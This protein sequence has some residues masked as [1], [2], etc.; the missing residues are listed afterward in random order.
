MPTVSHSAIQGL[1]LEQVQTRRAQGQGNV[2]LPPTSRTYGEI[3]RENVFTFI[4]ITL[5]FLGVALA[6]VGRPTDAIVSSGVITLN[7]LVSVIQEIRAKRTLD[8]I[9]LLTRPQAT[10]IRAGQATQ[11][12]PEA[13]VIGDVLHV[14]AGD[15]IVLDG[16]ILAGAM[17]V[18]ES[19]LTGESDVIPK[20]VG[21]PVYSGSFCVS[22]SAYLIVEKV[23]SASLAQQITAGARAFR[24]VLTPLQNQVYLV[25][26][27][28]FLVVGYIAF[29]LM[30]NA[31]MYEIKL[32]SSLQRLTLVAGLVPNGLFLSISI[33]YA[34]GA[35]R[36]IRHGVLVQQSNA[37]ESLSNVDV[38]CLDKTG[39]LTTNRLQ[40][41]SLQPLAV[42]EA[43]LRRVL[44]ALVASAT[45]RNKTSEALAE[46]YPG[47]TLPVIAEI[48]FSSARKWSAVVFDDPTL[49]GVV[50]LGAP[51][52]V[53]PY[54]RENATEWQ[55]LGS[56]ARALED[57]GLRVVLVAQHAEPGL[58]D[59]GDA[60]RLPTGMIPLG[61]VSLS[62]ELRPE[63]SAA[64]AQFA[65]AGV[66]PKIISGDNAE[67]VAALARQAGLGPDIK[68][69]SGIDLA[70]MND[71]EFQAA[72]EAATIFGRISPQQKQ[73]LI[74]ALRERGH[75]VAMI[76]DGVNDVLA[77]KQANLGVAMQSGAQATRG[78]AD[79]ILMRDTFASLAPAVEEG[80]RILNGMQ[81][82]LN[83]YITRIATMAV[84][85]LSA[86]VVGE[87]PLELRQ[88]SLVT[89]FSVGIPAVAIAFWAR[90]GQVAKYTLGRQ[91]LHFVLTPVLVTSVLALFL[92][93]GTLLLRLS[94]DPQYNLDISPDKVDAIYNSV[95]L[96]A[97]STLTAFL[98]LCGLLTVIF[99][100]PPTR[101]WAVVDAASG[102]WR[103]T[104]LVSLQF[105]AFVAILFFAPLRA[106]FSIAELGGQELGLAF[107]ATILW[108]FIVRWLWKH[109]A[110][111]RFLGLRI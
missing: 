106:L 97:Q 108:L 61:L 58:Q 100:E 13:L 16:S 50:A 33:A 68:L 76:G 37:I 31:V 52:M 109:Q 75:Y 81:D 18:D 92:F 57:Q 10:V 82:I 43:E 19:Q 88:A 7:I 46:K 78:V 87:F 51:E 67:T 48:P 11:V 39:T 6:L 110:F 15:Q 35:V 105:I 65:R 47:V 101:W 77:L 41:Q 79:L 4:N 73:R 72:A 102:D 9:A 17:A 99:V 70:N 54:L 53:R 107:S 71:A 74:Q 2:A 42:S 95:L 60:S 5:F 1:T 111:E 55:M 30:L 93:Y 14:D 45:S 22:G 104:I 21:A 38:L 96:I 80:Q 29:L 25:I 89:L 56:A 44:G 40:A 62:D 98:V 85:I 103:P 83:L 20:A 90:P 34:L 69:V 23:G 3:I 91:L 12:A 28:M 63:A 36:I 94:Q 84:L 66:Q 86:L 49:R 24:R 64:L 26:R 59:A 27:V 32:A 8:H